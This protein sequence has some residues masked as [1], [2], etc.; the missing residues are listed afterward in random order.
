[1]SCNGSERQ[2]QAATFAVHHGENGDTSIE[3][4]PDAA[5]L[6]VLLL[7]IAFTSARR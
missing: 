6:V 4:S 1:M 3:I 5:F 7:L 2:P